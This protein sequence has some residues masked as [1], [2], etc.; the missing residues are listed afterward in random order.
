MGRPLETEQFF[1]EL[2]DQFAEPLFRHCYFRVSSREVAEDL[3]QETFTRIWDY[4]SEGKIITNPKAFL[5]RTAGNLV[6]DYYR[7]KKE[8]SLDQLSESGFDPV[9]VG[10]DS[11]VAHAEGQEALRVVEKLESPYREILILKYVDDLSIGEIAEALDVSENVVS[12]RLHRGIEKLQKLFH[13]EK[14]H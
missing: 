2:Y 14:P 6:I 10:Q 9:G 12:V 4:L 13:Y 7:K 11:I 3:T 5:Y 1:L 8:S